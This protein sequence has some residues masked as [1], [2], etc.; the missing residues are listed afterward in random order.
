MKNTFLSISALVAS[1][2][3][4]AGCSGM[5]RAQTLKSPD[6]NLELKFAVNR[7]GTPMYSLTYKGKS[8]VL[9]SEMGFVLRGEQNTKI[10]NK[11]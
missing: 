4:F 3:L 5:H 7:K 10:R 8:I 6:G 1:M 9:P 2:C 11:K